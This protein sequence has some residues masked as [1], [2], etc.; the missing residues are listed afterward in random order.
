[1]ALSVHSVNSRIP[2]KEHGHGTYGP[3]QQKLPAV[4]GLSSLLRLRSFDEIKHSLANRGVHNGVLVSASDL[5]A[6]LEALSRLEDAF[7]PSDEMVT[8]TAEIL[9][10]IRKLFESRNFNDEEYRTFF[11]R[12]RDVLIGREVR[13][14]PQSIVSLRGSCFTLCG[15]SLMGRTAFLQRLRL[16]LGSP[17]QIQGKEPEPLRMWCVPVLP[18]TVPPCGST[19]Q[20]IHQ[21]REWLLAEVGGAKAPG[22]AL[23]D[24]TG[25]RA[26]A[27][28]ISLC[29]LLNVALITVDGGDFRSIGNGGFEIYNFLLRLQQYTGIPVVISGT[30]A[31]MHLAGK[32][33]S[34][35]SNLFSGPSLHF[36]PFNLPQQD[37][38]GM[39]KGMSAT[40]HRWLWS[41]GP[42]PEG[43]RP[44]Q[45]LA[46]WMHGLTHG[47]WGWMV[48]AYHALHVALCKK[49]NLLV[50]GALTQEKVERLVKLEL[51]NHQGAREFIDSFEKSRMVNDDS[52]FFDYMDHLPYQAFSIKKHREWLKEIRR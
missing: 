7:L 49:P 41:L 51:R 11:Y 24:L 23:A 26:E 37:E 38:A 52:Q 21:I 34:S 14:L 27:A 28:A 8:Y 47:R 2:A 36:D 17:F 43:E 48:I 29:T 9:S 33:G 44:P 6:K 1:M 32:A 39:P 45:D 10:R 30:Y 18:L 35:S 20:L 15:P 50:S 3:G 16:M 46:V 13:P 4:D 42:V 12:A 31:F 22:N 40:A 19:K 25:P 5:A